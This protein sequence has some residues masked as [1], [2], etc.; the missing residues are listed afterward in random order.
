VCVPVV[1]QDAAYVAVAVVPSRLSAGQF[2]RGAAIY[3][4]DGTAGVHTGHGRGQR[5]VLSG[6][7]WFAPELST[8]VVVVSGLTSCDSDPLLDAFKLSPR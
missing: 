7:G 5:T 6:I 2:Q 3:E 8:V 1:G 4:R